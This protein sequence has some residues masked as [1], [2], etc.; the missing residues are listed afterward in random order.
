MNWESEKECFE[1]VAKAL[2]TLF[3][4]PAGMPKEESIHIIRDLLLPAMRTCIM[5]PSSSL[6]DQ[7][8]LELTSLEQLYKVFERC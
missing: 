7:S 3:M 2:S 5:V 8:L 1:G 4:L 6:I